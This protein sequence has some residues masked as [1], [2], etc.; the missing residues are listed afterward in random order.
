MY[1]TFLQSIQND[2]NQILAENSHINWTYQKRLKLES[3]LILVSHPVMCMDSSPIA[4]LTVNLQHQML[5]CRSIML[6]PL[7]N[8]YTYSKYKSLGLDMLTDSYDDMLFTSEL[9]N[10][11][12]QSSSSKL[13]VS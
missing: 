7:N 12:Q 1:Y 3:M 9:S 11:S 2:L 6:N 5:S 4:G 10:K 13:K 8:K